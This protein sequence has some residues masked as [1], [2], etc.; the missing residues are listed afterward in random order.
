MST[1][2][3]KTE[4]IR[5]IIEAAIVEFSE[6]DFENSSVD[7]IAARAGLSKGGVYHHFKS[8]DAILLNVCD[9]IRKTL[10]DLTKQNNLT[11]NSYED[12][13]KFLNEYLYFWQNHIKELKLICLATSRKLDDKVF[14]A[15]LNNYSIR[16][17]SY[18]EKLL[19]KGTIAGLFKKHNTFQKAVLIFSTLEG[20]LPYLIA[21]ENFT[22]DDAVT[23]ISNTILK[24]ILI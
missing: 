18:L 21:N 20:I 24:E 4:R 16:I 19:I 3:S 8:K 13:I 7:S 23:Y 17:T 6:R 9:E 22:V 5:N 15:Q 14:Q 12:I 2:K 1:N 11:L 10:L